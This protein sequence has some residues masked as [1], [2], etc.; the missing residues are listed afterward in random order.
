MLSQH[1]LYRHPILGK[2]DLQAFERGVS[3]SES[4][5]IESCYVVW[6]I[7]ARG[8]VI[9]GCHSERT[10]RR[11]LETTYALPLAVDRSLRGRLPA[12]TLGQLTGAW[13]GRVRLRLALVGSLAPAC[14][15]RGVFQYGFLQLGQT[16]T[17]RGPSTLVWIL[18][19]SAAYLHK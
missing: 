11:Q 13:L 8:G 4:P 17:Q 6:L 3:H 7:A 9:G 19:E 2:A 16:L 5:R 12:G 15:R 14:S 18:A 10:S 1:F